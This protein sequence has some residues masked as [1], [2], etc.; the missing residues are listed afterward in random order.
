MDGLRILT[1]VFKDSTGLVT[2]EGIVAELLSAFFEQPL[3]IFEIEVVPINCRGF[4]VTAGFSGGGLRN[5][6]PIGSRLREQRAI[7]ID[8][9][10]AR[11]D[12]SAAWIRSQEVG[13]NVHGHVCLCG[14]EVGQ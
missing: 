8:V 4:E 9:S 3:G 13:F 14:I 6:L 5:P 2:I 11:K 1:L 12:L 7:G 10:D